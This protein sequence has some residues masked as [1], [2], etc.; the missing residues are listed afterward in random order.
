MKQ[1]HYK[2]ITTLLNVISSVICITEV[3]LSC[4]LCDNPSI[5]FTLYL[6]CVKEIK[7]TGAE[8]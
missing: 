6:T 4:R 3:A 1:G 2:V 8:N 5:T 7:Q